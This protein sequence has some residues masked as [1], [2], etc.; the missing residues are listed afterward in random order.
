[1]HKKTYK[2]KILPICHTEVGKIEEKEK[3]GMY[4]SVKGRKYKLYLPSSSSWKTSVSGR[5]FS[6]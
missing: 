1:M 5:S 2:I 6:S 4:F 3:C